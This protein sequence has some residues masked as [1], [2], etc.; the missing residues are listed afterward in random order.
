M[1]LLQKRIK[2]QLPTAEQLE[3]F[4]INNDLLI[5]I[6]IFEQE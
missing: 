4:N 1:I 5:G 3:I 6:T 2:K